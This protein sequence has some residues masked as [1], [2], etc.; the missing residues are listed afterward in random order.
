M[1]EIFLPHRNVILEF[2]D[3]MGDDE[4]K[5][6]IDKEYPMTGEEVAGHMMLDPDW[7]N[8]DM[9]LD[10]YKRYREWKNEQSMGVS[11]FASAA[12]GAFKQIGGE[13]VGAL[14]ELATSPLEFARSVPSGL[15]VGTLDMW[16]LGKQIVNHFSKAEDTYDDFL[17]GRKDTEARRAEYDKQLEKDMAAERDKIQYFSQIREELIEES[18]N[19]EA[20]RGQANVLDP[21]LPFGGFLGKSFTK[22]ASK[23]AATATGKAAS[24][25]GRGMYRAGDTLGEIGEGARD[26]TSRAFTGATGVT[27]ETGR[28]LAVGAGLG[29]GVMAAGAPVVAGAYGATK[30]LQVGGRVLAEAGE[31][32]QRGLGREGFFGGA[33]ARL[34]GKQGYGL[35]RTLSYGDPLLEL[36]AGAAGGMAAG[37]VV[38]MGL[39]GLADGWEGA[40]SGLGGGIALGGFGGG[41]ARGVEGVTGAAMRAKRAKD[42]DFYMRNL[43]DSDRAMMQGYIDKYGKDQAATIFDVTRIFRGPLGDAS[44]KF[45]NDPKAERGFVPDM[46]SA[47]GIPTLVVNLAKADSHYTIGH[48]LWHGLTKIEQLQPMADAIRTEIAGMWSEGKLL[49]EGLIPEAQLENFFNDYVKKLKPS[50]RPSESSVATR[51][52]RAKYIVDEIAGD[53]MAMVI[54]GKKGKKYDRMMRG[55]DTPLRKVI[56][57]QVMK[58]TGGAINNAIAKLSQIGV[59]PGKSMLFPDMDKTSPVVGAMLR[60]MVRSRK[61]LGELVEATDKTITTAIKKKDFKHH[62]VELERLNM[63][64]DDGKGG[65]VMKNDKDIAAEEAASD[66]AMKNILEK[67]GPD[68]MRIETETKDGTTVEVIRGTR[69]SPEQISE[70]QA[71]STILPTTRQ[72]VEAFNN[73]VENGLITDMTYYAATTRRK[74]RLTGLF[75]SK[76]SSGIKKSKRAVL[77]YTIEVSNAGNIFV[78]AIDWTKLWTDTANMSFAKK[79]GLW[80][81]D[82]A[83]FIHEFQ[84]YLTN[85]ASDDPVKSKKLFGQNKADFFQE[86]LM[87]KEKGGGKY[88]KNFRLDRMDGLQPTGER[89]KMSEDAYQLSKDR[90]M[91]DVGDAIPDKV[92]VEFIPGKATGFLERLIGAPMLVREQYHNDMIQAHINPETNKLHILEELK[93]EHEIATRP[94]AYLNSAGQL[95]INP[96]MIIKLAKGT[97]RSEALVASNLFGLYAHQEGVGGYKPAY[98]RS[99]GANAFRIDIG[100]ELTEKDIDVIL[101]RVEADQSGGAGDIAL[102]PTETGVDIVHLGFNDAI[103]YG[104][105]YESLWAAL[106]TESYAGSAI[107]KFRAG[108]TI[109]ETNNWKENRNGENYKEGALLHGERVG[110]VRP[111]IFRR[112][113]SRIGDPIRDVYRKWES[114]GYGDSPREG[115]RHGA[116]ELQPV[117]A[118][119]KN[120]YDV[121][122]LRVNNATHDGVPKPKDSSKWGEAQWRDYL[123][124]EQLA[125][126]LQSESPNKGVSPDEWVQQLQTRLDGVSMTELP[127]HPSRL[128]EWVQDPSK[129]AEYISD[130]YAKNP[131]LVLKSKEGLESVRQMHELAR[132][133]KLPVEATAL[134]YFWGFLSRMLGPYDQEAGWIRMVSNPKFMEQLYK[135]IDGEF[136]MPRGEYW[137]PEK[138]VAAEGWKNVRGKQSVSD[139]RWKLAQDMADRRNREQKGTWVELVYRVTKGQQA[140]SHESAGMNA[141]QNINGFHSMLA[142]WNGRWND[143]NRV[144]NDSRLTGPQ[145]REA[146][147]SQGLLSAG[148]H[149]K[150]NSFVILTL[151]RDDVVIV[152][153]W[154]MINFWEAQLKAAV[155]AKEGPGASLYITKKGDVP[156]EKTGWSDT[157]QKQLSG[158]A[159]SHALY[160][161][162]EGALGD[163]SS[164][165][166]AHL[167]AELQGSFNSVSGTHWVTWNIAKNEPVGHSSLDVVNRFALEHGF[168]DTPKKRKEFI[169]RFTVAKKFTEQ[170]RSEGGFK[171]FEVEKGKPTVTTRFMPD[172]GGQDALGMFSAAERA[173]VDLK[174]EKG[175]ASQML[176]MIKKAGVKDEELQALGLDKFLEGNRRVTRDEIIDHLVENSITVE[177]TVLG[178]GE[179]VPRYESGVRE[180]TNVWVVHDG[181]GGFVDVPKRI[182][183]N[184]AEAQSYADAHPELTRHRSMMRPETKHSSYVEPGAVEGSYRE[185]LLRLPKNDPPL[186]LAKNT[187]GNIISTMRLPN[188]DPQTK[189]E[190]ISEASSS[191]LARE[192]PGLTFEYIEG[193]ADYKGGHY[194][195]TPNTLAHVRFND[196]TSEHG[197]TL[198]IEEIQSDWHQEGR[199]KGYQG[200]AL[201]LFRKRVMDAA[202]RDGGTDMAVVEKAFN[203]LLEEP[204]T[205]DARPTTREW[206]ILQNAIGKEGK[207]RIDLNFFHDRNDS[208]LVPDAPF[209][210]SWHELAMKR[211]IKYAVDNGY[212]AISW[213]KGE[214]QFQRYGSSEIAWV[215]DGDG[216]KVKATEQRGSEADGINIEAAAR[217]EGILKESGDTITSKEQLHALIKET[218][219]ERERGQWSPENFEKQVDKLTD[220]TWERMQNEDAGTSLPRKEG[221]KGFYDRMLVKMKTWKK[222]GLKVETGEISKLT[223]EQK[224]FLEG[225]DLKPLPVHIVKLT[226]EVKAKVLDTGIARFM[227]DA[228]VPGAERNSIGWSMLLTKAG[229]WRVYGPDGVLAGVAGSKQRAEQ[230]FKT[231]YKRE[232]RKREKA[233]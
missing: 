11:E 76:Y 154:Q 123:E 75:T 33:A 58:Q 42:V 204:R 191:D 151:A 176:A 105:V 177:E 156:V 68:G 5:A 24:K 142:R 119:S 19:P 219:M 96:S 185:L 205:T 57:E 132:Q 103:K 193:K 182:A 10:E 31:G 109:Y 179:A 196:R 118:K 143:V 166:D 190:Y 46:K 13:V 2:P 150:V 128:H 122:V 23:V 26:V 184:A 198:F 30:G 15:G 51:E 101:K 88:T 144:L 221:M 94:S 163:V 107:D 3:E 227:P 175:S 130:A 231:K 95:E 38:G 172:V 186:L 228:A 25:V 169:K 106:E 43:S 35:A 160:R 48:E 79:L 85:L 157:V 108:D 12:G 136:S 8:N 115:R 147:W 6:A 226:P 7:F 39:G 87:K 214:T 60:D 129:L 104:S 86:L 189:A 67:G 73:A 211:M 93:I 61:N 222:L 66:S 1:P 89:A 180:D 117:T 78:R 22:A 16:H 181:S 158:M 81:N 99:K 178:G 97:T 59:T 200:D 215:K 52:G 50:D 62:Q 209:K 49:Q 27:P 218:V 113:D 69:F 77:P 167:P 126:Q 195:D 183:S 116:T 41:I 53:H 110:G 207:E 70:I 162:L 210:T 216:W 171:R 36:G 4:I 91:V 127:P 141:L 111:D 164:R 203:H 131:D 213:T 194:G 232:L 168:P 54:T 225:V 148:I 140:R 170:A 174:Q 188:T 146:M 74:N 90:F 137:T 145:M 153:R 55:F 201:E 152:D 100:R 47:E 125:D 220:R 102:F 64:K 208:N 124:R 165:M 187:D 44:V 84:E 40:A 135:S 32:L 17:S 18:P 29:G 138:V 159:G 197:K 82:H 37:G 233:K 56:D 192:N 161:V 71:N 121:P 230:I 149:D 14:G 202:R 20:T 155:E 45:I 21:S 65:R 139:K 134:N 133:G 173:T 34:E 72:N 120:G 63:L 98:K 212:D 223:P 217:A 112:V 92:S 206:Q 9:T 224:E 229:N 199:K 83:A 28:A 114:E 80:D